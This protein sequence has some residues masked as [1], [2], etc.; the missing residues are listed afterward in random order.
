V[1]EYA[2]IVASCL[3]SLDAV[4]LSMYDALEKAGNR[5]VRLAAAVGAAAERGAGHA[6]AGQEGD[7]GLAVERLGFCATAARWNSAAPTSVAIC[8]T[9]WQN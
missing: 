6:A 3:P 7:A 1:P 8:M 5:P 4:D 9:L 2:T